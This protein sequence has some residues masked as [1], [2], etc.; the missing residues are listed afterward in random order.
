[1]SANLYAEDDAGNIGVYRSYSAFT[2]TAE[3]DCLDCDFGCFDAEFLFTEAA[4]LTS[5]EL[6][7]EVELHR[8][9]GSDIISTPFEGGEASEQFRFC[10][11]ACS[12][13]RQPTP[14]P[15]ISLP[16][17][18]APSPAPS[19]S[20]TD[21][22]HGPAVRGA[23]GAPDADAHGRSHGG[24]DGRAHGPADARA[25]AGP[26]ATPTARPTLPPTPGAHGPADAR[27]VADADGHA[28]GAPDAAA[29]AAAERRARRGPTAAPVP[30]PTEVPSPWPSVGCSDPDLLLSR[31]WLPGGDTYGGITTTFKDPASGAE[32][33]PS[34]GARAP[35]ASTTA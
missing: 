18:F 14:A 24:A 4:R 35:T 23:D 21:R 33:L 28:D 25:V 7:Y 30:A 20:P 2:R 27:A 26:D 19:L 12:I 17:T 9:D 34:E 6:S 10:L 3:Y 13:A 32:R 1:M 11:E 15:T 8:A 22:A 29:D 31:Q 5:H 16:P